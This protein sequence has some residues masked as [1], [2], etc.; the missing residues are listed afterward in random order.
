[1][2]RNLQPK[3]RHRGPVAT[4]HSGRKR[5]GNRL[6]PAGT[7]V[8]FGL[9]QGRNW[10]WP[11]ILFDQG[12]A[13][14]P[15]LFT[16]RRALVT[17][18]EPAEIAA[19][20]A[21]MA[22]ARADGCWLAG[23]ASYELG[24]ALEPKLATLMPGN[25]RVPLLAFEVHDTPVDAT[26]LLAQA[27]TEAAAA[28]LSPLQPDW[29]MERYAQAFD[30]VAAFIRAGDCYQVNLTMPIRA[31]ATGTPLG[32]YGAL[33]AVQPVRHGAFADLGVGPVILSRSPELFFRLSADGRIETWPMKGTARR[34][35]DPVRDAELKAT[36]AA[37]AK[38]RAE[39][40]MIVD[41]LRNDI[42]RLC[43]VGSVKVPELYR[44]ETYATVHQMI[45]RIVGQL[46]APLNVE[47]LFRALFPCGSITGA[48]KI[49]AM[50]VIRALEPE[51]RGPYCG[52]MGWI[53]PDGAAQFNVAIRTLSL[54][55][56]GPDKDW[57]V[58]MN[59]GGG[60][61]Y[62]STAAA[63]YEEALWKARFAQL[64]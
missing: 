27:K 50:E 22:Q 61:V 41:L 2:N 39:N 55:D 14:Q 38:N 60:I 64:R 1:M 54:F 24:Y 37:S 21:A 28:G 48:P 5:R 30:Q 31:R 23:Y 6:K 4:G 62:D 11:V 49:R 43:E 33:R 34:D 25:R 46:S 15:V 26:P 51:P 56:G 16:G 47:A 42:S 17:A 9:G 63:E 29:T 12:P 19:A 35:P 20:F 58:V 44:V 53:A 40:L 18:W 57:D 59:V 13:R 10:G 3:I 45:S 36:L 8:R 7:G 32:L 52:A